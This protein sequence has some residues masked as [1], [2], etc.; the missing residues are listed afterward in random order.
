MNEMNGA[1]LSRCNM[2]IFL[3]H[4]IPYVLLFTERK[5][6]NIFKILLGKE[7]NTVKIKTAAT[8]KILRAATL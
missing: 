5:V 6:T 3:L 8:T 7:R 2:Y 1:C 4:D